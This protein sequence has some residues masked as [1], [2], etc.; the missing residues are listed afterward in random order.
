MRRA[1]APGRGA[2]AAHLREDAP[3]DSQE[4]EAVVR[5][6][7]AELRGMRR[8]W[9]ALLAAA[10]AGLAMFHLVSAAAVLAEPELSHWPAGLTGLRPARPSAA[11]FVLDAV[12]AAALLVSAAGAVLSIAHHRRELARRLLRLSAVAAAAVLAVWGAAVVRGE[13]WRDRHAYVCAVG[14]AVCLAVQH[15]VSSF[16]GTERGLRELRGLMYE[17]KKL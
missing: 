14:P 9:G 13:Q 10:S 7:E 15:A 8:F 3:L 16:D 5:E 2:A 4:Q 1:R 12:A 17:H 11:P 6:L